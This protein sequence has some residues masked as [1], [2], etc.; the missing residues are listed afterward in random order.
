M[1][2]DQKSKEV[3][4]KQFNHKSVFVIDAQS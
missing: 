2:N 4:H 1:T 3:K